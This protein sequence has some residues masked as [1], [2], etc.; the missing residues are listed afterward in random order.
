MRTASPLEILSEY[1][2][3]NGQDEQPPAL[4]G[5][6]LS[7]FSPL[8]AA[9]ADGC[10]TEHY[11]QPAASAASRQRT[12]VLLVSRGNDVVS[13]EHVRDKVASGRRVGPLFFFQ[14]AP[15]SV[16]GQV[17]GHWGL[18][19]PVVCISPVGDPLADGMAEAALLL[20]DGDADEVLLILVEQ[21]SGDTADS[22]DRAHAL[23]L[24]ASE[25]S[26]SGVS[27]TEAGS[28]SRS[29]GPPD[30]P[31]VAGVADHHQ[32]EGITS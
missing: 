20:E 16:V 15:N 10:L 12:A 6:V 8:V 3:P 32:P 13:A 14:A 7:S 1:R 26:T 19:G 27:T 4:P 28:V 5:Y 18:G 22:T 29:S 9:V 23:L 11:A 2:W 21:G 31:V 30:P 24:S 25:N 17:T